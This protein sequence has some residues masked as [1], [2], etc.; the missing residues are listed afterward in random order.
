MHQLCLMLIGCTVTSKPLFNIIDMILFSFY[1]E[2]ILTTVL[3]MNNYTPNHS[4]SQ[5]GSM[6]QILS[7]LLINL[8]LRIPCK[9]ALFL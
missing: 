5:V 8:P 9:N 2:Y 7:Y 6:G 4:L 1:N 3:P